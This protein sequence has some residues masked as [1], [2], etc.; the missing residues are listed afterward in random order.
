MHEVTRE[1]SAIM[2]DRLLI[3]NVLILSWSRAKQMLYQ[4]ARQPSD[5]RML[6]QIAAGGM[7]N[8]DLATMAMNHLAGQKADR[9]KAKRKSKP[10]VRLEAAT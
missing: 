7:S 3:H 9:P 1:E 5:E 4:A 6:E 8:T 2:L 10:L